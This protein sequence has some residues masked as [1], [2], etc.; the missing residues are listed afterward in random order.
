MD[1]FD[2]SIGVNYLETLG[3]TIGDP[4]GIGPELALRVA[5][6]W[7]DSSPASLVLIGDHRL[8]TRVD[9]YR[10]DGRIDLAL[11]V[12]DRPAVTAALFTRNLVKAAPVLVAAERGQACGAISRRKSLQRWRRIEVSAPVR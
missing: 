7:P 4:A 10:N 3:L 5:A 1:I 11:A 8:L 6:D 9:A 2:R 12:C